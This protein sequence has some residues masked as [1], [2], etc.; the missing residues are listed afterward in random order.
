MAP[1]RF[2]AP[3]PL[4]PERVR[5]TQLGFESILKASPEVGHFRGHHV[6]AVALM[7]VVCRVALVIGL[8]GVVVVHGA[9]SVTRGGA[10]DLTPFEFGHE[11][12][13]GVRLLRVVRVDA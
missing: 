3:G 7:G 11:L 2:S 10:K 8:G 5:R 12:V 9:T 13:G 4:M 6:G 1:G